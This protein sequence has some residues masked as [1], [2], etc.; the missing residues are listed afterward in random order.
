MLCCRNSRARLWV[1]PI[2]PNLA[3]AWAATLASPRMP[4]MDATLTIRPRRRSTMPGSTARQKSAAPVRF[5]AMTRS[6][7]SGASLRN[8]RQMKMPAL[9]TRMSIG[10]ELALRARDAFLGRAADRDVGGDGEARGRPRTRSAARG[11]LDLGRASVRRG[12]RARL[13]R[14]SAWR[15]IGRCPRPAP[16]TRTVRFSNFISRGLTFPSSS[17][18]S[19]EKR[20]AASRASES[21]PGQEGDVAFFRRRVVDADALDREREEDSRRVGAARRGPGR[22]APGRKPWSAGS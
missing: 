8:G 3:A 20:P 13:P 4:W 18:S 12:R 14:R 10:P 19:S 9:L 15:W 7:S 16:V 5:V 11:L 17:K 6:Q 2:R 21:R 22:R 1:R